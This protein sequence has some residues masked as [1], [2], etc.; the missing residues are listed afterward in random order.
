MLVA[1]IIALFRASNPSACRINDEPF[2]VLG[3]PKR[4][5]GENSAHKIG[6]AKKRHEGNPQMNGNRAICTSGA[7]LNQNCDEHI[8]N[9]VAV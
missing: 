3:L 4:M 2:I 5:M 8:A 9:R 7:Q 1:R 6:D